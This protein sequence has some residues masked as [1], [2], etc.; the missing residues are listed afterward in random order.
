MVDIDIQHE[1]RDSG[2]KYYAELDGKTAK[3]TYQNTDNGVRIAEH[4]YVPDVMRGQGIAAKLVEQLVADA[5]ET[6]FKIVPQCSYVEAAFQR[7]PEWKD[8][9]A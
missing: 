8:L 4:T 9:R 7:H 2:G 6:P 5:R 1:A 3:L